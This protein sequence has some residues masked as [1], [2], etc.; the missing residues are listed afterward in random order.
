MS[1][2]ISGGISIGGLSGVD[3]DFT[4]LVDQLK[5]I[6]MMKS[7][8]L[9]LWRE[10]WYVRIDSMDLILDS[11]Q[12]VKTNIDSFTDVNSMLARIVE[13]T[14]EDVATAVGGKELQEGNYELKVKRLATSSIYSNKYPFED[15][16]A[17][18]NATAIDHTFGFVYNGESMEYTV[19]AGSSIEQL[20]TNI[21]KDPN[22]PGVRASL[23]SSGG[24]YIFQI[25]GLE[26]GVES[27]LSISSSLPSFKS[28][29]LFTGHDVIIAD[30]AGTYTYSY[31]GAT[32]TINVEVGTTAKELQEKIN[33]D[34]HNPGVTAKFFREGADYY[35]EFEDNYLGG[36]VSVPTSSDLSGF[37]AGIQPM[38][39]TTALHTGSEAEKFTYSY[40]GDNYSVMIEPGETL[41]DLVASIN[42]EA[43]NPGLT[44]A[45]LENPP[46]SGLSTIEAN[47]K[48]ATLIPP[49][50]TTGSKKFRYKIPG[51]QYHRQ[52]TIA[53]G[54]T[55]KEF[56][57]DFNNNA[58]GTGIKAKV[59][60]TG[61]NAKI[62][63]QDNNGNDQGS[64]LEI[65]QMPNPSVPGDDFDQELVGDLKVLRGGSERIG[66]VNH[67]IDIGAHSNI[68]GL[69][70][71]F[72]LSG[73]NVIVNDSGTPQSYTFSHNSAN[74]SLSV[75]DDATVQDF[76]NTFNANPALLAAGLKMNIVAGASGYALEMVE[77]GTGAGGID[78]VIQPTI[79]ASGMPL[80]ESSGDNWYIQESKDAEFK[81]NGWP[82]T[83]TSGSNTLTEVIH[84]MTI[85]LKSTGNT[86]FSVGT[87]TE[88]LKE[89]IE[90]IVEAVNVLT[91]Q[92]KHATKVTEGGVD[93]DD[94][95]ED[96]TDDYVDWREGSSLTGNYGVQLVKSGYSDILIS[97]GVG[98]VGRKSNE[99][100]LNDMF[101][102]LTQIG[103]STVSDEG[104]P[105][106]GLLRIDDDELDKAIEA[107]P[108]AVAEL[109]SAETIAK[110]NATDFTIQSPGFSP[111]AGVYE[112]KYEV[113]S[114]GLLGNVWINGD[115]A[116]SDPEF[117]GRYTL[118]V[119]SNAAVGLS[120]EF[121]DTRNLTP[122]IG[123]PHVA[124]V[125]MKQG[126]VNEILSFIKIETRDLDGKGIAKGTLPTIIHNYEE[127][128]D[129]ID[130]KLE[131]EVL[132]VG[133]WEKRERLKY[134]R[135]EALLGGYEQQ[136]SM[137]TQIAPKNK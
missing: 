22:N 74:Y 111:K 95:A 103:I 24:G 101:T 115:L 134:A 11:M 13:S 18:V 9:T 100:F 133:N 28:T 86:N 82:M 45:L 3:T 4:A 47:A 136:K 90:T 44:A 119:N 132:R 110:T 19:K 49:T 130:L 92:I 57:Q 87:D 117:P 40:L 131:K 53:A 52:F 98:F 21:N 48:D 137:L 126:K 123:G 30:T 129:N 112:I 96:T 7:T 31:N 65:D 6:E 10:E 97:P 39:A 55:L 83:L 67:P 12:L 27:T 73:K 127:I 50:P 125:N 1:N 25:Q 102:L 71:P 59:I 75:P 51:E 63:Y 93:K 32:S 46:G 58:A 120:I 56:E 122:S 29:A 79:T 80:L 15:K 42:S 36:I 113:D 14:D 76:A 17:K 35:M 70:K 135:L 38:N 107:D 104:D 5:E 34:P 77:T 81:V 20:V 69:G 94:D 33:T 114:T 54:T 62:E 41:T 118:G 105:E 68:E 60:I 89:N 128:I 108:L 91:K 64:T 2:T 106:F 78:T 84:G 124:S 61:S 43:S 16:K 72:L 121:E 88:M 99:D 85:T 26:T 109:L 37:P 23:I 66:V 8:R 116:S